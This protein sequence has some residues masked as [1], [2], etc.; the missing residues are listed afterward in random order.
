MAIPKRSTK[1]MKVTL[2]IFGIASFLVSCSS[3]DSQSNETNKEKS[4]SD[5]RSDSHEKSIVI[6]VSKKELNTVV[7]LMSMRDKTSSSYS[8]IQLE[9]E[10]LKS[11]VDSKINELYRVEAVNYSKLSELYLSAFHQMKLI[12]FK[13]KNSDSLKLAKSALSKYKEIHSAD[14][15]YSTGVFTRIQMLTSYI[16]G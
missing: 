4:N 5:S 10:A 12:D 6:T 14:P 13:H 7:D 8:N 16:D 11:L 2:L 1:N 15:N 9:K 3:E